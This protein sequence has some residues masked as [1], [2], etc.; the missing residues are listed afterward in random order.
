MPTGH[1]EHEAELD[2]SERALE[3]TEPDGQGV[4]AELAAPVENEFTEQT[5]HAPRNAK[6]PAA[7]ARQLAVLLWFATIAPVVPYPGAQGVHAVLAAPVEYVPLGHTAHKPLL[8][9]VP[10]P[11]AEQAAGLLCAEGAVLA[12]VP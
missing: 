5:W 11:Q 6:Y 10:G 9:N 2:L 7:Q 3:V 12:E 8:A 1:A 4:Q